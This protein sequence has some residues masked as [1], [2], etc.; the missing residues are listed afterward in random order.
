M[1][2]WDNL[3][4]KK[5]LILFSFLIFYNTSCQEKQLRIDTWKYQKGLNSIIV[6]DTVFSGNKY[7]NPYLK[8][9]LFIDSIMS[10]VTLDEFDKSEYQIGDINVSSTKMDEISTDSVNY[11]LFRVDVSGGDLHQNMNFI[12]LLDLGVIAYYVYGKGYIKLISRRLN[13]KNFMI[14]EKIY[15]QM[16][17]SDVLFPVEMPDTLKIY[18]IGVP[19]E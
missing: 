14:D 13:G 16:K 8:D 2:S 6:T 19:E 9:I 12:Y 15:D 7:E 10:V 18:N 5:S 4:N 11:K 3:Q 17:E 1:N